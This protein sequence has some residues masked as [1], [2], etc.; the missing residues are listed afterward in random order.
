LFS[1]NWEVGKVPKYFFSFRVL[2]EVWLHH[3]YMEIS[4][5]W[6]IHNNNR[7]Y[8]AMSTPSILPMIF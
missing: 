6:R 4:L 5:K 2:N 8:I 3:Y 7:M 1:L